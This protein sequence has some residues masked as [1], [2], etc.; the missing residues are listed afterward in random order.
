[1]YSNIFC[2]E[3]E[4]YIQLQMNRIVYDRYCQ[5]H[6]TNNEIYTKKK[7][8]KQRNIFKRVKRKISNIQ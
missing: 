3:F 1:M 6:P 4:S 7:T 5:N 2:L 8:K